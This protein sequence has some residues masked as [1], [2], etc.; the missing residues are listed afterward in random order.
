VTAPGSYGVLVR[1]S[2]IRVKNFRNLVNIDVPLA[3]HTVVVGENRSGKSNLLHAVR[4]VLDSTLSAEQ[5][6]LKADDFWDGLSTGADDAMSAGEVIEVSLDITDFGDE[7]GVLTA[8]S[9]ALVIGEPITARLTY[10]WEPDPLV[11]DDVVY[12]ARLYGGSDDRVIAATDVRDRLITV[13][14]HA[15]RDVESDVRSWRRSPLRELLESASRDVAPNDLESVRDAMTAANTALN[16]LGPLVTLSQKI[17]TSTTDAVGS[18]QGLETTLAAAPPDPRRLIRAM[19]LFVDGTAQRQLTS[20]SLGALNVLY[21]SLLELRLKQRLASKEAAH[22][23]L[24]VEEP[25]AH[26]HPHLQRLLFKHLQK[27]DA[28]RSTIVT[29]H[30]PHIA[31]VASARNLVMLRTTLAGSVARAAS[32]AALVDEEWEDI[33]RYLD[34]TRSELVFARRVLLVEGVAE[35]LMVPSLAR[36]TGVDLDEVGISV[37]AIGGT[38]FAAYVKLCTALDIPWAVLTDGDPTIKVTGERRK[39]LLVEQAGADENAIFVGGTTFE[40]DLITH[41]AENRQA[42]VSVIINLLDEEAETERATVAAWEACPPSKDDFISMI[43]DLGGKGRFAQRL[44]AAH[45]APPAHLADAIA[46][47]L[48][49]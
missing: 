47:L 39:E 33:D 4:L 2:R 26:L 20:T 17:G 10:R 7:S 21:F 34:A 44:A 27:D 16:E 40:H 24:A 8:L 13:F 5:R 9:D 19:Q 18:N 1:L 3:Q 35:Q 15:L 37:C 46:Y 41:S 25:E 38:H 23:L 48:E 14:M 36:F 12:R 22:V 29:T 49:Q 6:R 31:S 11:I 43:K 42:I 30:S 45:L 32:S 28:S